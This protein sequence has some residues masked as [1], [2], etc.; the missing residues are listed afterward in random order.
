MVHWSP[1]GADNETRW[2]PFPQDGAAWDHTLTAGQN[3]YDLPDSDV[4]PVEAFGNAPVQYTARLEQGEEFRFMRNRTV[5]FIG[6]WA[7]GGVRGCARVAGSRGEA[8]RRRRESGMQCDE[9][10]AGGVV[11]SRGRGVAGSW[12]RRGKR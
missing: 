12:G 10:P 11:G 8:G 9:V 3:V 5:L 1:E 2:L 6:A 7:E 4:I